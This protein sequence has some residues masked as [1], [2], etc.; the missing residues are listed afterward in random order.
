MPID[1]TLAGWLAEEI[2]RELE[3]VRRAAMAEAEREGRRLRPFPEATDPARL[4]EA[5]ELVDVS[6]LASRVRE[7]ATTVDGFLWPVF[8][9]PVAAGIIMQGAGLRQALSGALM[10]HRKTGTYGDG[11]LVRWRPSSFSAGDAG[12][13]LVHQ[14]CPTAAGGTFVVIH[15]TDEPSPCW[16]PDEER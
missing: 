7:T 6:A 16:V 5:G 4:I 8:L 14:S 15:G 13:F 11:S 9:T 10:V 3:P 12:G 1:P 2:D